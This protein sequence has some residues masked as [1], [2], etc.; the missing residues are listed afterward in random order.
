[1]RSGIPVSLAAPFIALVTAV[2]VLLAVG[3]GAAARRAGMSPAAARGWMLRTAAVVAIWMAVT[4][5]AGASG[6]L[7]DFMAMPP[8]VFFVIAPSLALAVALPLS[9]G[10]DRLLRAAPPAWLLVAQLF[11][12]P[13]EL[14]LWRMH[15]AGL[16]A[17]MMTFEGS[18]FDILTALS[19]PLF[20]WLCFGGGR[21]RRG[22]A[23]LWN[24]AGITLLT[25]V[26]VRGMLSAPTRFQVFHTAPPNAIIARFP[27]IWLP[28]VLVAAPLP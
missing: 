18:N 26:V 15:G 11:R 6:R 20:A 17:R 22:L 27:F 10:L 12:L 2:A 28:C 16:I 8:R 1:M 7:L 14:C 21:S 9:G 24:W 13:V 25:N 23:V 5:L 19:A 3:A 4:G